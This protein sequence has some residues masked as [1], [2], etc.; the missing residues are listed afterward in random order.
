MSVPTG[1][2]STREAARIYGC[3]AKHI[4]KL[5]GEGRIRPRH[6]LQR[7]AVSTHFW[8]P[9]D[10]LKVR[11]LVVRQRTARQL[12]GTAASVSRPVRMA[13][14]EM[15]RMY[16]RMPR[17]ARKGRGSTKAKVEAYYGRGIQ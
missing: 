13:R 17:E 7:G 16:Y 12:A 3:G 14:G 8:N 4:N 10:V 11:A 9:M 1:L 2:V 6:I 5:H 15:L